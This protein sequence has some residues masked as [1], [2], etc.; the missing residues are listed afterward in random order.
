MG[1]NWKAFHT[2]GG[3]GSKNDF[4][5]CRGFAVIM[6]T[7]DAAREREATKELINILTTETEM[8]HDLVS[9]E[10]MDHSKVDDV[11]GSLKGDLSNTSSSNSLSVEDIL[12][13]EINEIKQ[14][15]NNGSNSSIQFFTSI[16]TGIK[17]IV[18]VRVNR[19]SLCP[20]RLL[21]SLFDRIR[22][23]KLQV[24]RYLA[25]VIPLQICFFPTEVDLVATLK[26]VIDK[27]FVDCTDKSL[28][29]LND[30]SLKSKKRTID[31][32][33]GSN[34][35][36]NDDNYDDSPDHASTGIEASNNPSK[37]IKDSS[38]T[39]PVD[40]APSA[41]VVATRAASTYLLLFKARNH[42]VLSKTSCLQHLRQL[43]PPHMKQDYINSNVSH[44]GREVFVCIC[45]LYQ[46]QYSY[47]FPYPV[48]PHHTLSNVP[49][50]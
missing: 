21:K 41:S 7:C 12:K 1:K 13:N 44:T 34:N 47:A 9:S 20:V 39:P 43:M 28:P 50:H 48:H 33:H 46:C 11:H 16:N 4:S 17:G 32:V 42:N 29:C 38:T 3:G 31:Q 5:S 45:T 49:L 27:E 22:F 23:T 35:C 40:I 15:R 36:S 8:N 26:L 37:E 18:L 19:K 24:S 14:H 6:G 10:E 30:E 2:S 25:K